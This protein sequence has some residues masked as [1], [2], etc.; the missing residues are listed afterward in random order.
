MESGR[1]KIEKIEFFKLS[2]YE[3]FLEKSAESLSDIKDTPYLALA[4]SKKSA[5]W[6]NDIHLKQQSLIK[7]FTTEELIKLFCGYP[8]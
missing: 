1:K 8:I 5:I 2:A 3:D 6:S 7:I 4:L